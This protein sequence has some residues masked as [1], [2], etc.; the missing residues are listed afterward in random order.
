MRQDVTHTSRERRPV[1]VALPD[2]HLCRTCGR[3]FVVPAAVLDVVGRHRYLIELQCTNCGA[4]VVE[5][6]GED[7]LEALDRELDRQTAD[8]RTALELWQL[9]RR[10]EEIEAFAHALEYDHLLPEDF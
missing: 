1:R 10:R 2:L 9:E 8:M 3:P 6:H 7:V 4:L 5:T